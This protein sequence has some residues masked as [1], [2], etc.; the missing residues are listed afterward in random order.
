L[1]TT[2][3]QG[4]FRD[5]LHHSPDQQQSLTYC[6]SVD[7]WHEPSDL[8]VHPDRM[9]SGDQPGFDL[10]FTS[11]IT[12]DMPA[13]IPIA[14]LYSTPE[15]GAAQLTYLKKRGYP[16]WYVEMGEEPDGQYMQ[17]ED[18]G[19]L[20][21][22]FARALHRVDPTLKLGG[23]V[24]EGVT[25]DIKV[26]ADAQG[27]NSWLG[28]FIAYLKTH[29]QL[30]DLAFM[31]FEHYPYDGCETPWKNLYQEPQLLTHIMQ[32]WRD[33][34]LPPGI[35]LLDTET[36]AH[37]GESSVDIFGALWLADTFS[38]FLTAG[39]QATFY[40]HALSYS[41][42]HPACSNSWGTYHL[43]MADQNY[44]IKQPTSQF[45]AAQL[46]T[47]EWTQ[48]IDAQHQILKAASDIKDS[49]GNLLVTA[50]SVK[51]PDGQWALMLINKDHDHAH[52]VR[53]V[54]RGD[55]NKHF[56]G[57]VAMIT[58]GKAQYQWHPARRNGYADPDGPAVKS[59]VPGGTD[60]QY[61]LPAASVTVLRGK[62]E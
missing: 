36:N 57:E 3:T 58:F 39:G 31:S 16:I 18:Y 5:L 35:P 20:Y 55:T 59:T 28:R 33:D 11:G 27:K 52:D 9:E 4:E 23:P 41:P 62:I 48:P 12:R 54:F 34:G 44:E 60:A 17:P 61:T 22:Q 26:W 56:T 14:M 29:N 8:Y 50:Y 10:F 43:F 49:D 32:V 40:Y 38:A 1:G 7:P 47:K 6:S 25:E 13:V 42:P 19:A 2:D 30:S 51:R 45:F 37:G 15:D 24:F 46:L 21:V 53:V